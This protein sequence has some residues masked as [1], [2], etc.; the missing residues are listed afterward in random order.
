[1]S[2]KHSNAVGSKYKG[3]CNFFNAQF[4]PTIRIYIKYLL[5]VQ[6]MTWTVPLYFL[7]LYNIGTLILDIQSNCCGLC[8]TAPLQYATT[9]CGW[10]RRY[11]DWYTRT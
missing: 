8:Q 2:L 4:M 1:M 11:G 9:S 3:I 6:S 5:F 10:P 7:P